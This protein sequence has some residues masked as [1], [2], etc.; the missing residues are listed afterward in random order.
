VPDQQFV[1][2]T[3]RPWNVDQFHAARPGLPGVWHL[4]SDPDELTM[5]RLA[6]IQPRYVFFPHWS[7]KVPAEM[8]DRYECV[9]FHET[10][11]PYGRGGSPIQNL[12][13][14]GHADT[15]VSA[16]R[17][18]ETFDAGPV[19][20]KRP[21]SLVGLA[22]EIYLRAA[23][24]VF[25]MIKEIVVTQPTPVPQTGDSVVFRRRTPEQSAVPR[26][27]RTLGAL[28]DHIRMLDAEGYPSAFL[29]HGNF[30]IEFIRPALRTGRLEASVN[31]TLATKPGQQS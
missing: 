15:V 5:A 21:L 31:I 25:E 11:L 6:S 17:M 20:A 2:A 12:I 1:V 14:R 13:E 28:F 8:F 27:L 3:I 26:D 24:I 9:A 16:L 23:A 10:D 4:I 30:R 19:Y 7:H 22:E 29:E 18:V